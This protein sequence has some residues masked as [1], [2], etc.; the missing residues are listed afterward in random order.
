[1]AELNAERHSPRRC[2]LP[3]DPLTGLPK[4]RISYLMPSLNPQT[5]PKLLGLKNDIE[6][7][8]QMGAAHPYAFNMGGSN[9][10]PLH[11]FERAGKHLMMRN[12]PDVLLNR[13]TGP[14]FV[15]ETYLPTMPRVIDLERFETRK[16]RLNRIGKC[17]G[18]ALGL[19]RD[20]VD[21]TDRHT[22][23]DTI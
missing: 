16:K 11:D 2:S 12:M 9:I 19:K 20:K 23:K 21:K 3:H 14:V 1:M 10:F 8:D 15:P 7:L 5:L 6:L 22:K 4:L 13:Q 17:E 18:P